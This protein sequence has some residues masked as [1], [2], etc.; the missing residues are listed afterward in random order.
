MVYGCGVTTIAADKIPEVDVTQQI[1]RSALIACSSRQ[2]FDL[3]NDIESYPKF[4]NGCVGARVLERHKDCIVA[5]LDLSRMGMSYSFTTRN[6]LLEPAA[7]DMQLVEGPFKFF[8]GLW[9]FQELA[10]DACKVCL[11]LEFEFANSLVSKAAGKWFESIANELVDG[12]CRRANHL[13]KR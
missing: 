9:Q 1:E 5:K 12:V 8:S 7:M 13:Y 6:V 3:V 11:S 4:M 10:P 2:M